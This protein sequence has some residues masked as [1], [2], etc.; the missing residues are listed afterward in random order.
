[1]SDYYGLYG[2]FNSTRYPFPGA[3]VGKAQEDFV[4]LMP[5]AEIEAL[6]KPHR[7]KLAAID[8]EVKKLE[9]AEAEAKKLPEAP[10]KKTRARRRR[11]GPR[12][13][14]ETAGRGAGGSAD[15]R[16]RLC[17][18]GRQAGER[19]DAP[20][21]RSEAAG[22]RGAAPFPRGPRRPGVAAQHAAQRP[23]ATGRVAHRSQEPAHGPRDGE[24]HLAASLRQGDRAN[25]ERF[26]Q[27]GPAADASRTAR[28]PRRALHRKRLVG[29]GD[30][31]LILLSQ[32]WQLASTDVAEASAKLDPTNE[33]FWKFTR[34]RLDAE[35]I[36]DTMLFVSGELDE[37][38][39]GAHPFPPAQ[40][41]GFTQ[42]TPF[43]A[44][45]ETQ[46]RSVYLMQQRLR[47]NPYLAL[48]DGADPSSSTGVRLPSTT[49]LQALFLMNDP[50]A[51]TRAAKFA[52]RMHRRGDGRIRATCRSRTSSP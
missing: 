10:E 16:Q 7:E 42:H 29:E 51:H 1:M 9:A 49:P 23:A 31:R 8:A 46:R 43:V 11:E 27:A 24:S 28:L 40:T 47:K 52:E 15:H 13:G 34:R 41:W 14:Q 36:R 44:V 17:R 26:R 12:R 5:P 32:T 6:L 30:A 39:G 3:E 25:A 33:L 21:R 50:L 19:E 2:I 38:A 4:P 20:A 22:R 45:Y 18:R 37:S 48:F 35:S